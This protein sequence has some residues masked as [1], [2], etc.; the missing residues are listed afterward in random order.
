MFKHTQLYIYLSFLLTI[1]IS[2]FAQTDSVETIIISPQ[3]HWVD[4]VFNSLS[5]D[6]RIAQLI[7]IRAHSNKSKAYHEQVANTIRNQKVGGLC[8]F[9]GGPARQINLIEYYQNISKTPLLIAI[10]GEWG[11]SMRLDSCI[12]FPRQM[13]LGAIQNDSL[14]YEMGQEVAKQCKAVGV[15]MNFAP[16]VDVNNN[17]LNPVINSRS[18]GENPIQVANKATMYMKGMQDEHILAC[19]KHFPGHGDTDSD[20]HK[21]LP[22]VHADS[23]SL[24]S[25]HLAPFKKLF[26][27]GV[28]SVMVAHLYIPALDS[29]KNLATTL[30]PL[31]VD[32]LLKR[33]MKFRGLTITDALEMKGVANYFKPGELEI[34]ALQAGN[35]ILLMPH[36][37]QTSIDSIK[38]AIH[39][40]RLD[41]ADIYSR[42]KLILNFKYTAGLSQKKDLN[43]DSAYKILNSNKTESLVKQLY[44]SSITLIKNDSNIL[45]LTTDLTKKLAVVS[46][47]ISNRNAYTKTISKYRSADFFSIKSN[48][49]NSEL[50][51]LVD[52]LQNYD[53]VIMGIFKT[54]NSPRRK[55]GIYSSTYKLATQIS[56]K[57]NLII[58]MHA[59]PYAANNFIDSSRARAI[60]VTY[61][62]NDIAME[63]AAEAIFGGYIVNGKL[64][65]SI[66]SNYRQ[67]FGL[68]T[69]KKRL[70]FGNVEEIGLNSTQLYKIDSIINNGIEAQAYPGCQVMIAKDGFVFYN[71]SFGNQT[72]KNSVSISDTSIYD[73][74]SLT[75]V[76]STTISIMQLSKANKID[77]DQ[78][79]GYYLPELDST[80]KEN[81]LIRNIMAHQARLTPW[82]PFY[83]HTLNNGKLS[84]SLFRTTA[85]EGYTTKVC[86]NIFILNTYADS[87]MTEIKES[88]LRKKKKY[89]YSDLG[90]YYLRRI[91]E[92][93]SG[94][95]IDS[96]I[97]KNI[98]EPLGLQ[99]IGY[100]PLDRFPKAQ[101]CPTEEDSYFRNMR[102]QGYVHDQAAAMMGG[103]EG[104]AGLFSNSRD[105]AILSEMLLQGGIY[106][107]DTIIDKE[108]LEDFTRQ[109]FPLND[110]RRGC[111]FDKPLPNHEEGGPTCNL[112]S[113]QSFGHS[114]FTGTYF[115]VDPEYKIVYVFLSNRT[116][117][118][119]E[120]FKLIKMDIRTNIQKEIYKLFLSDEEIKEAQKEIL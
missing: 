24:D 69:Q 86:D 78:T 56:S 59:N 6:E 4:S 9:Q 16:V 30:S 58:D 19:A 84:D 109:Q 91:I 1:G 89:K 50:N 100:L 32:S 85:E 26:E 93:Q 18:F 66:D 60:L 116:Y 110:N 62:D 107:N 48:A 82:I 101:I 80:N 73:L 36:D 111:G 14:I 77:I 2:S 63:A 106:G 34:K 22:T 44:R 46:V 115:W 45:P 25:I 55:Y 13:T 54:S 64:P 72:Y 11:V 35:D 119:S 99:T 33:K 108:I 114:G 41:S 20:S 31:V 65:V 112:V 39:D 67:G 113:S 10:D 15:D 7:M 12:R 105:I 3:I 94:T 51:I 23:N 92:K 88:D 102:I 68:E 17:P 90:M 87:I 71:K 104:H 49:S 76:L 98:Y 40:G 103:V 120:N 95:N 57:T 5:E 81:I 53:Y 83:I 118:D 28:T 43:T 74:A 8:F 42:V 37:A 75:K 38:A 61:Q 21:T 27:E 97:Q 52:K 47:G 79:L 29:T 70:S 117:P 96:Y